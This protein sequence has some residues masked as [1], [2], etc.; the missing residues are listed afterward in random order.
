MSLSP[1]TIEAVKESLLAG[2]YSLLLGAGVSRDA[3]DRLGEPLPLGDELRSK[4]VALKKIRA[5]S[6]L[7]R[8]YAQLTADEVQSYIADPFSGCS[9]GPTAQKLTEFVWKRV[10]TLNVDDSL[11]HA[12][13]NSAS[14]QRCTPLTHKDTYRHPDN[15]GTVQIV[16]VHGSANRPDDGYVFSLAE[17]T[18]GMGPETHGSISSRRRFLVSHSS[19]LV[20]LWRSQIWSIL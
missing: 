15:P 14:K 12:Y 16:H 19:S 1:D 13:T 8:A 10:Y 3:K 2:S 18:G 17:Y 7:A 6:S 11:E 5:T 20:R 9:S 4:L